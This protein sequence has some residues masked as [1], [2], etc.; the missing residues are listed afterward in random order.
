MTADVW[1]PTRY[2]RFA[3]ERGR[4]FHD[5]LAMVSA[6]SP[7]PGMRVVD[8]GCG[9]GA[10]TRR[11]HE[12]LGAARTV[13]LD[14]SDAMLA[15]AAEHAGGGLSFVRGDLAAP[16]VDGALDLVFSN[17][18]LHW[19][20]DHPAL[21]R[22]LASRLAPGG[23]LAVQVPGNHEHVS[24]TTAVDVARREPFASA[25]GGWTRRS[26]VLEPAA[27]AELLEALGFAEQEVVCRIYP[28][29]LRDRD[30]LVDWMA[31]TTLTDT[32]RRLPADL[33][34]RYLAEYRAELAERVPD[35]RPFFFPFRRIL[36][37]GRLG[38]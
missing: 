12:T 16:P 22:R 8:L 1:D 6:R 31:G 37:W 5:L 32:R 23:Q 27:Y 25:L 11:L 28:H 19:V 10:L 2:E 7:R 4:P 33:Y 30:A 36:F 21:L 38:G 18:A 3:E 17:A 26:P 20:G 9:T 15:R 24:Q 35:A 13:G 14:S 29:H 34:D